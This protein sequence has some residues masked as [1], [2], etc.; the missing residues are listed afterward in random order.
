MKI[1]VAYACLF[2]TAGNLL[3]QNYY[4]ATQQARRDSAQNDAE[5]QRIAKEANGGA[6]AEPGAP[7]HAPAAPINPALAATLK[8][9][10]SLQGDFAGAVAATNAD[11]ALKV[12]LLN[13]L[14]QA[15]QGTKASASSVKKLADDVLA[16][17]TGRKKL[18]LAQ[19]KKLAQDV[20]ALFN[21]AH[22]TDA[23]QQKLPAE[24]QKILTDADASVDDAVN[25]MMDLKEIVSQTK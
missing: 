7:T 11:A 3:A 4:R 24:V 20:H 12:S 21:S 9:V 14:T 13:D 8:N 2:L 17:V 6:A 15:A 16:A 1:L 10:A 22:L 18:V 5:Q 19:Q 25:V 23:Q